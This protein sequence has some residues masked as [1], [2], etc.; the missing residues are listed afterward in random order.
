M[1]TRININPDW[2]E[3]DIRQ[4]AA[5]PKLGILQYA[6]Y[7]TPS[8]E[9]LQQLDKLLFAVRDD[10]VLRIYGFHRTAADLSVLPLLQHI[11]RLTV[12]C[13]TKAEHLDAIAALPGLTELAIDVYEADSLAVLQHIPATLQSL[14]LGKTKSRKYSLAVLER[15]TQLQELHLNGQANQIATV[16]KLSS[17]TS[18]SISGIPLQQL[19]WI[20]QLPALQ[21]LS[22]GFGG[23][24]QLNY[25]AGMASLQQLDLLRVKGLSDLSVLTDLPALQ[26]LKVQDQPHLAALPDLALALKLQRIMLENVGLK[27][28][29]SLHKAAALQKLALFQ[30]KYLTAA[31][32]TELVQQAP[33]LQKVCIGLQSNTQQKQLRPYLEQ[34]GLWQNDGWWWR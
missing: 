5:D 3:D 29:T 25:L 2:T 1:K 14:R 21:S 26:V 30:M 9:L 12:D 33:H 18:L 34:T 22:L 20:I 7:H 32:I 19:D 17:L 28:V 13:D 16:A 31:D 15:F 4:L 10:V 23:A 8:V 24:E 6:E 11:T 27:S